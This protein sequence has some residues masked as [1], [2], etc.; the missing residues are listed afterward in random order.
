MAQSLRSTIDKGDLL[1]LKSFFM[2]K[3]TVNRTVAIYILGKD[4]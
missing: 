2:A 3:N 4:F 1:N